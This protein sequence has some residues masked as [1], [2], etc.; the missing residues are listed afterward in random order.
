[1]NDNKLA[2][3]ITGTVLALAFILV[4]LLAAYS[5]GG[6]G[7]AATTGN[8]TVSQYA[9]MFQE[10]NRLQARINYCERQQKGDTPAYR[11]MCDEDEMARLDEYR[12]RIA[13]IDANLK[14]LREN[15][16]ILDQ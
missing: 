14:E 2:W 1:M 10:R 4:I 8:E 3:I 16:A 9:R 7:A 12:T 6:P 11:K 13:E 5:P 15:P